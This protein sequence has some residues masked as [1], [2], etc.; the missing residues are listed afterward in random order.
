MNKVQQ[1]WFEEGYC[2]ER[3]AAF[4][5]NATRLPDGNFGIVC[6]CVKGNV[7]S[8]YDVD[9]R[10]NIKELLFNLTLNQIEGLKIRAGIFSQKLYFVYNG[11]EFCFTNFI[12]VKPALKVLEEESAKNRI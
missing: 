12:G 10:N 4:C 6:L 2:D 5:A 1:R 8:I 11:G 9:M 3:G 7:L